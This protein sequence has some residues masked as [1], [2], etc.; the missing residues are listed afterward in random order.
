M[1]SGSW[2]NGTWSSP[3]NL[4]DPLD[5]FHFPTT[6]HNPH[7][8]TPHTYSPSTLSKAFYSSNRYLDS[9]IIRSFRL[10]SHPA[11]SLPSSCSRRAPAAR[12]SPPTAGPSEPSPKGQIHQSYGVWHRS[13]RLSTGQVSS[14]SSTTPAS[15]NPSL[16]AGTR[17]QSH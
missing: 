8:L 9:T 13:Q 14:E 17:T 12:A 5:L 3:K 15:I 1:G 10:S 4:D 11:Q 7:S 16:G 6:S 2:T